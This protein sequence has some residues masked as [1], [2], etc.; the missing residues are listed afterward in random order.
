[1]IANKGNLRI[2]PLT[3]P[4]TQAGAGD[5]N[6]SN[7]PVMTVSGEE[8]FADRYWVPDQYWQMN[9]RMWNAPVRTGHVDVGTPDPLPRE[10][11]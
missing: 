8:Y 11:D 6:L 1:M 3:G 2:I 4:L 10:D 5:L 9:D 7:P